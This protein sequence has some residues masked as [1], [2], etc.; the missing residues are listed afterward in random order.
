MD[1]HELRRGRRPHEPHQPGR[2]AG[3]VDLART[4]ETLF[5]RLEALRAT[6]Q[7]ERDA[8]LAEA[9]RAQASR[10]KGKGQKGKAKAK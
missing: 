8:A 4:R 1:A 5:G 2:L 3:D 6:L 7:Q 10:S 9:S